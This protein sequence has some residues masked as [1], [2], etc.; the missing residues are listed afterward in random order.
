MKP[1]IEVMEEKG[2]QAERDAEALRHYAEMKA[3]KTRLTAANKILEKQMKDT[4]AA[5]SIGKSVQNTKEPVK[6]PK[7]QK[8]AKPTKKVPMNKVSN[9][10]NAM[11]KY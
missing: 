11:S 7:V 1:K 10:K 2:W 8:A 6:L 9:L 3:D 4:S 5:M